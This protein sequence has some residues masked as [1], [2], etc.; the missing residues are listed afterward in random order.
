MPSANFTLTREVTEGLTHDISCRMTDHVNWQSKLSSIL[1]DF[2]CQTGTLHRTEADGKTLG[3]VVQIGVPEN[4]WEKITS[5]PFGKGIAGAAAESKEPV[6]LCTLQEDLG[7]VARVDARKT[8]VAGS[9]AVPVFS[10]A[11]GEVA[12][13]LG[14]GKFAPYQFSD[15]EKERLK[16]HAREIAGLFDDKQG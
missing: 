4:L 15:A 10:A 9:L 8:G 11:T 16:E 5:I 13:T 14:I 3:L 12:G 7:G 6:E 2:G 1:A